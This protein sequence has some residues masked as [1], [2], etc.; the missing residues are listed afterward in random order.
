MAS[1][2]GRPPPLPVSRDRL[3][4]LVAEGPWS[5][6]SLLPVYRRSDEAVLGECFY[7]DQRY[8]TYLAGVNWGYGFKKQERVRGILHRILK[9]HGLHHGE[10]LN[11]ED[12]SRHLP[13]LFSSRFA[14]SWITERYTMALFAGDRAAADY[15][16]GWSSLI[17]ALGKTCAR[18][19][20]SEAMDG[21][22]QLR[23]G[24]VEMV[25][26]EYAKIDIRPLLAVY[27]GL[28][29]D[30]AE[31]AEHTPHHL[32]CFESKP[33]VT[34]F[35]RFLN[36]RCFKAVLPRG[37]PLK[38]LRAGLLQILAFMLEVDLDNELHEERPESSRPAVLELYGLSGRTRIHHRPAAKLVAVSTLSSTHGSAETVMRAQG[39]HKGSSAQLR[40]AKI[41]IYR[42]RTQSVFS[43]SSGWQITWDGSCHGGVTMLAG[44]VVDPTALLGAYF[45][46][47]AMQIII[48]RSSSSVSMTADNNVKEIS[49]GRNSDQSEIE[50]TRELVNAAN[51]T[52][53][54][55][56]NR[57]LSQSLASAVIYDPYFSIPRNPSQ[58]LASAVI[59]DPYFSK[60]LKVSQTLV[61]VDR[62]AG[63]NGLAISL[64]VG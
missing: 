15:N 47:Q 2:P 34:Q 56:G 33:P 61:W 20:Q 31:L 46:P 3:E 4:V 5:R 41:K 7:H 11:N 64:G 1:S 9:E 39:F 10:C 13:T 58:S 32:P 38:L 19:M 36:L 26:E 22:L 57:N 27:P 40:G 60:S 59:Y 43:T 49:R 52:I 6:G 24:T 42:E 63:W 50:T 35:W 12:R 28:Q 30:W 44:A 16:D 25:V 23:V 37:H 62:G 54:I 53:W 14:I 45:V 17:D 21:Q 55:G 18:A 8:L 29:D 48:W 51:L